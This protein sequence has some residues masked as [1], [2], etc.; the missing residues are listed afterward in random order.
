MN[1]IRKGL[2]VA[3]I[4]LFIGMSVSS[5]GRLMSDDDTTPPEI[6][7][8][9]EG[10]QENGLWYVGIYAV[11]YDYES[12]MNRVEFY[13][14]GTLRMT[15]DGAGPDYYWETPLFEYFVTGFICNPRI[16]NGYVEF[17]AITV[18]GRI[19]DF[20]TPFVIK[21]VAYDNAGNSNY[22]E[23]EFYPFY[24]GIT[25]PLEFHFYKP[26]KLLNH[27]HGYIG[28]FLIYATFEDIQV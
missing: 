3:V 1:P 4:V 5:T 11:C 13:R 25:Y 7:L 10:H 20:Y 18:I 14:D 28:K 6:E 12:G 22:A 8:Q 23:I 9:W 21:A 17:F 15:V 19:H 2:A 26:I 16:S 27:Y 24:H